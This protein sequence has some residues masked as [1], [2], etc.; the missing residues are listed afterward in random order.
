MLH[1][2][3]NPLPSFPLPYKPPPFSDPN[4][5]NPYAHSSLRNTEK[6]CS[7]APLSL[8]F[9]SNLDTKDRS[10]NPSFRFEMFQP[11]RKFLPVSR[12]VSDYL[13]ISLIL[14]SFRFS[15][16]QE[17]LFPHQ[18]RAKQSEEVASSGVQSQ[19]IKSRAPTKLEN[20]EKDQFS[21]FWPLPTHHRSGSRGAFVLCQ[22]AGKTPTIPL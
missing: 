5:H 2:L 13:V 7:F 4:S 9:S 14:L 12:S 11:D 18:G 6:S 15:I 22:T 19:L 8:F 16:L 21:R 10:G 17:D 20:T 3:G 1:L